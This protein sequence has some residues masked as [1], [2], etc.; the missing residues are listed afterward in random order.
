VKRL[1]QALEMVNVVMVRI[2]FRRSFA[3][4]MPQK[5]FSANGAPL[6][7]GRLHYWQSSGEP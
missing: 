4:T 5:R 7:A 6:S 1:K 3:D 2:K